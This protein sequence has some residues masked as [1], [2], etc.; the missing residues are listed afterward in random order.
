MIR[1][2]VAKTGW[3]YWKSRFEVHH[4]LTMPPLAYGTAYVGF[5]QGE[6]VAHLGMTTMSLNS[7]QHG[8]I[9][10]ARACRL[11]VAPEWQGA[12]LGGRFLDMMAQRELDGRGW[13]GKPANTYFHT[14]HPALVAALRRNRNWVQMSQFVAGRKSGTLV[15]KS[16]GLENRRIPGHWRAVTGWKYLGPEGLDIAVEGQ[17]T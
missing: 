15:L 7:K 5:V 6:P 11:V 12:G 1:L 17:G 10:A 16:R 2:E 4:Y 14:A 13:V 8:R 3:Q 9:L